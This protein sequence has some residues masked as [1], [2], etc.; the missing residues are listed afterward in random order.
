MANTK[1]TEASPWGCEGI[2]VN[3]IRRVD[4]ACDDLQAA[5]IQ[6]LFPIEVG[7]SVPDVAE[8][9]ISRAYVSNL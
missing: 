9:R 7:E 3:P 1:L 6:I 2:E 8:S 4:H 5:L